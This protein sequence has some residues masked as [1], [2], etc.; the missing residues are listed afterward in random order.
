MA[1]AAGELN[2]DGDL[3]EQCRR[4]AALV[5]VKN[6]PGQVFRFSENTELTGER[7]EENR[8]PVGRRSIR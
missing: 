5:T 7:R 3:A 2:V 4:Y 6:R 8:R 1:D